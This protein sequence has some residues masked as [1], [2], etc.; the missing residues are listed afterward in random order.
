MPASVNHTAVIS[1]DAGEDPRGGS[2]WEMRCTPRW[3]SGFPLRVAAEYERNVIRW[4]V[5]L[6]TFGERKSDKQVQGI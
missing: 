2:W 5:I 6:A 4:D 1:K 3:R